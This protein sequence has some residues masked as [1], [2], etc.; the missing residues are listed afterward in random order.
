MSQPAH[1]RIQRETDD[2][3]YTV[4]ITR[5][6]AGDGR[7]TIEWGDYGLLHELLTDILAEAVK[8]GWLIEWPDLPI[9]PPA[10]KADP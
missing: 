4:T 2:V 5:H 1:V 3:G 6:D 9:M 10:G 7:A 8:M